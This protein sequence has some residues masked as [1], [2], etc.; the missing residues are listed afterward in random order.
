MAQPAIPSPW[1]SLHRT[2][3]A[4]LATTL[5]LGLWLLGL[6]LI[7]ICVVFIIP[8]R[9]WNAA[10]TCG[11]LALIGFVVSHSLVGWK[12]IQL[13]KAAGKPGMETDPKD[14]ATAFTAFWKINLRAHA[15]LWVWIVL[16]I[17]ITYLD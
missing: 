12:M 8:H 11:V 13:I 17:A 1:E 3:R 6:S 2:R 9:T 16:L 5:A 4:L 14:A 10:D 15:I 7:G